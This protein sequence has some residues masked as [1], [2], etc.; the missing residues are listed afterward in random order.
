MPRP[1]FPRVPTPRLP[2]TRSCPVPARGCSQPQALRA[3]AASVVP[4]AA[5]SSVHHP[6]RPSSLLLFSCCRTNGAFPAIRHLRLLPPPF[7]K[8]AQ[9]SRGGR[10]GTGRGSALSAGGRS[11][12][13]SGTR[14]GAPGGI[15]HQPHT[16]PAPL[17]LLC[18]SRAL[19]GDPLIPPS[20]RD[21]DRDGLEGRAAAPRGARPHRLLSAAPRRSRARTPQRQP[22][23]RNPKAMAAMAHTRDGE[24]TCCRDCTKGKKK[25]QNT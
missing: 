2:Q 9:S 6:A 22:D 18:R 20:C 12:S 24:N 17:P 23:E 14:V 7:R 21:R 15:A 13:T 11:K 1:Q 3:P 5:C 8:R 4:T 10:D 16:A 19:G 25:E